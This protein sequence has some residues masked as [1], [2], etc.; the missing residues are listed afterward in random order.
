MIFINVNTLF[1]SI[2]GNYIHFIEQGPTIFSKKT[3]IGYIWITSSFQNEVKEGTK[4]ILKRKVLY[5]Q[6]IVSI[7]NEFI[8][9]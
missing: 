5:V 4:K 8:I 7:S 3:E 9:E 2:V 6:T 1:R